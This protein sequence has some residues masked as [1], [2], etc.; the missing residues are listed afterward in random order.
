MIKLAIVGFGHVGKAAYEAALAAPDM[1]VSCIVEV[2]GVPVP[3]ALKDFWVTDLHDI[4]ACGEAD[5][6]ILCLPSRLCP[7]AAETLL[8]MGIPVA[9]I[10][11]ANR[12]VIHRVV[13]KEEDGDA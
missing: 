13:K 7:D 5:A 12:F 1:T 10:Y 6:A 2:P 8:S 9:W 3:F 4:R 11:P